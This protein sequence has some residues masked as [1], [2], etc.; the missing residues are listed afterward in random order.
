LPV[1]WAQ[2]L[3]FGMHGFGGCVHG[4]SLLSLDSERIFE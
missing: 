3:V 4:Q 2:A 1:F